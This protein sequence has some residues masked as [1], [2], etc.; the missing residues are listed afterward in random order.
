V[1]SIYLIR[2]EEPEMRGRFIGR[3]DPPLTV[4]G[5]ASAASKLA[6]VNVRTI[7]VSPLRRA[8][9]TAQCIACEAEVIVVPELAEMHFGDWEGLLWSEIQQRSPAWAGRKLDNW[10]EFAAPGGEHWPEF[11]ARIDRAL[12]R[13]LAG[14]FPAAV[15]AHML[16]NAV[17]AEKLIGA[18][19]GQFLQQYGEILTCPVTTL[20]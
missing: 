11:R 8:M 14:P 19:P 12:E 20:K 2:H 6:G 1:S 9:Q 15:V 4:Q 18:E 16:V 3:M 13:V 5:R 10:F 17:L 7:F